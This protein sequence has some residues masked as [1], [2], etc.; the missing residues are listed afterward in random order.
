MGGS[1]SDLNVLRAPNL[2]G[3][4]ANNLT[5]TDKGEKTKQVR[6]QRPDGEQAV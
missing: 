2:S 4:H 5:G 6:N 1:T 3:A